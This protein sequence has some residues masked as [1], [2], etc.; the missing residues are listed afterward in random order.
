MKLQLR[1]IL[2]LA[3]FV[4]GAHTHSYAQSGCSDSGPGGCPASNGTVPEIDPSMT[5]GG[6]ILLAG[7]IVMIRSWRKR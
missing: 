5:S 3:L 6:L 4:F 7:S 1:M 2:A